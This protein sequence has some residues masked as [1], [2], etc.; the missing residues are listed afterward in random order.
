M[1]KSVYLVLIAVLL[2]LSFTSASAAVPDTYV[3][4]VNVTN[5]GGTDGNINLKFY[6]SSGAEK[7]SINDTILGYE[8][9][10]ITSF[11]GLASGFDGGMVISSD[12]PLAS[13]SMLSG[14]DSGG[15]IKNYASYVGTSAGSPDVY[16]PLLM[17]NNY[18]YATY[19]YVQNTST[20]S[21]N[22]SITYSDGVTASINN[23]APNAST[24]IDN[25]S[26]THSVK[27][28]SAKLN[29]TG[30]IAVAVVEY[31]DG[32]KGDQLY[33]YSGFSSGSPNPIFPMVN[34]NNYGYWTSVNIQNM[35]TQD[36]IVTVSYSPSEAGTAC[37]ETQTIPAGQK[38]DFATYAFAFDPSIYPHSVTTD[39]ARYQKFIGAAVVTAN[40]NNQNLVGIVNQINMGND[41]NKGGALGSLNPSTATDT[42]VYPYVRQ[43]VG[44]QQWWSSFTLINVSGG[45]I[46]AGDIQCRIK[47][48]DNSGPVDTVISNPSSLPDGGAWIQQ[49]FRKPIGPLND[50]FEG[51][52][53]CTTTSGKA[54][55]GASNILADGAGTAID[56][57][58]VFEG[59]NP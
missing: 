53:V 27:D 34:E 13:M 58:A 46:A 25:S 11:S 56:S 47:G 30:N 43:W 52:A 42:V 29:A 39:C 9:K 59:V 38:R 18:G 20:S 12:V 49:F 4:T 19:Y 32:S 8:T 37:T 44:S 31:S 36:T 10:W 50:G 51:G 40:S 5:V 3:S 24:K 55:V 15:N 28:F 2:L 57:L 6:D 21:V 1:R 16:L 17:K 35:G 22:V 7:A 45:S 54:I 23:L 14:K 26:E 41:P 33:A 48:Q